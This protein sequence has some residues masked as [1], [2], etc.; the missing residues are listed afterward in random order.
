MIKLA[1]SILAADFSVL[2]EQINLIEGAGVQYLHI[3]VMDGNYVPSISFGTPVIK[4]I[5]QNSKLIFD[6]HLMVEEPIRLVDDFRDAGA[7]IIT[8]HAEACKDLSSTILKIKEMGLKVGVSLNPV[9]ELSILD[10]II[11]SVD[12]V[13][14]MSVEPGAGG[15]AFIPSSLQKIKDLKEMVEKSGLAIDI[16]VDGGIRHDNVLEVLEAGA[17]VIVSGTS[18]FKGNIVENINKYDCLF[19]QYNEI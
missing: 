14:I 12:M 19:Q 8:V 2:G 13:L 3:D 15:Q 7:N 18:V 16:E 6:V 5:R 17:N 1:P 10:S 9:T 11:D 4:S